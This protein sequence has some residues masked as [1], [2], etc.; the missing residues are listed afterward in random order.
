MT[1]LYVGSED[2]DFVGSLIDTI[3]SGQDSSYGRG[4]VRGG[5]G[6]RPA[7]DWS[8][9]PQTDL[10]L[11]AYASIATA[12]GTTPG[13][14]LSFSRPGFARACGVRRALVG[15][16]ATFFYDN[17]T[18]TIV[19]SAAF[20][21][22]TGNNY[23]LHVKIDSLSLT[24]P[25]YINEII[26][27][28]QTFTLISTYLITGFELAAASGQATWGM[29]YSQ[30]VVADENTVGWRVFTRFPTANGTYAEMSGGFGDVDELAVSSG[31]VLSATLASK[32]TFTRSAITLSAGYEV[33]AVAISS[34]AHSTL[35]DL[36]DMELV[37]RKDSV[38]Y[39]S[40]VKTVGP[41]YT[42]FSEVWEVDPS[43]SAKW[44]NAAVT[45]TTVQFGAMVS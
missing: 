16:T 21:I 38:D 25:L 27:H 11:H 37:L 45:A 30:V 5:V 13:Y 8:T 36:D 33:K 40:G 28:T 20:D 2:I 3:A 39:F 15:T 14:F 22:I 24:L 23:D 43:T 42:C 4:A 18:G 9:N 41:G 31:D 19:E 29:R 1:I 17:G 6:I 44:A 12:S 35:P 7:Q 10:W 34:Y 32:S 26:Q